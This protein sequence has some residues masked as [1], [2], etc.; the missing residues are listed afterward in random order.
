[1]AHS[2]GEWLRVAGSRRKFLTTSGAAGAAWLAGY[3]N[4]R[5]HRYSPP[6]AVEYDLSRTTPTH[7]YDGKTC[8]CH[9]RAGAVPGAGREGR[10]R[11][12]LT[13]NTLDVAG[14]DVFKAV[15]CIDTDDLG[16]S[17]SRPRA[18]P[19]LAPRYEQLDGERRPVA[20]SD[21][22][23]AWHD[24]TSTLLATGHTVVYTPQW[25]VARPRPRHTA[26]SVYRPATRTWSRW[27]KLQMPPG[28]EFDDAGAG[29]VQ[30]LDMA[31][32][33]ILLPIYFRTP[34]HNSRVTVTRCTFDGRTLD[35]HQ[36][37]NVL[38]I[39]DGTRGL[40]E[41]SL[42]RFDGRFYLTIRNDK[43]GFVTR[44][45]DGLEYEPIVPWQFDDGQP[46]GNYNTQQ[47]W[48]TQPR[49]LFLVYTRRG[50]NNDH[51]F[52][53]RAPLFMAQVDPDTLRVVRSTERIIVPERGARLGNFGVTRVSETETWITVAEWMQT[54][55]PD[56]ILPVDNKY[57]ADGSVWVARIRWRRPSVPG[58]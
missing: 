16:R 13:M 28:G 45:R 46:L 1:M 52:R 4:G 54:W 41:P 3:R 36:H 58:P 2:P 6:A 24:P 51:V 29:C 31:D 25:K 57:G 12:V 15:Y 5:A 20:F 34:R 39:D 10:P 23:P 49:G 22:W 30:R 53:H 9:P 11:V 47:H 44:S 18:V 19:E 17:W 21:A 14:S 56:Y 27:Q 43:Q 35:Y 40:H 26:Y 33:S 7:R 32:G 50:A 42:T 38:S 37:G 55:G 48:V 8:W